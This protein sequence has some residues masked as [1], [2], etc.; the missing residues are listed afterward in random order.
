MSW[1]FIKNIFINF[2]Y[3]F[4]FNWKYI[5]ILLNFFLKKNFVLTCKKYFKD[6]LPMKSTILG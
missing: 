5:R 4:Y 3:L 6:F 2:I 1:I